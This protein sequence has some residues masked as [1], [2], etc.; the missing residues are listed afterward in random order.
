MLKRIISLIMTAVMLS[1]LISCSAAAKTAVKTK[2][3][4]S[5][6]AVTI[7]GKE[8][9]FD[10]EPIAENN[11]T[12]VPI[13]P[14]CE[15]LGADVYWNDLRKTVVIVRN[16]TKLFLTLNSAQCF[17]AKTNDYERIF[18]ALEDETETKY[19]KL[20][21]LEAAPKTLN[22][23]TLLPIRAV[24]EEL[25]ATVN[26]NKKENLIEISAKKTS[27]NTD[28]DFFDEFCDWA[29]EYISLS[30]SEIINALEEAKKVYYAW[31]YGQAYVEYNNIISYQENG[32]YHWRGKVQHSSIKTSADLKALMHNYFVYDFAKN[33]INK[34]N[35]QDV[36]GDLYVEYFGGVG[37][38]YTEREKIVITKE[39]NEKYKIEEY[40]ILI[41]IEETK[42]TV[43]HYCVNENGTWKFDLFR[44]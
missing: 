11:R 1:A 4:Q 3:A 40:E 21:E 15:A 6:I 28:K 38:P 13:R 35:P 32:E 41:D 7:N 44:E 30:D 5:G 9:E 8:I 36:G 39:S 23:R 12:L 29:E 20:I 2:T 18:D 26:W 31:M 42:W 10:Q 27:K 25:G 33:C 16:E 19:V 37:G 43:T 17:V 14:V 22:G 34:L 24:C